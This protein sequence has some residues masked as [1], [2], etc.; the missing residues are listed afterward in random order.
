MLWKVVWGLMLGFS[1]QIVVEAAIIKDIRFN[2]MNN[3]VQLVLDLDQAVAFQQFSLANPPRI[4]L[5]F[6]NTYRIAKTGITINQGAVGSI[7]TGYRQKDLLRVVIDL[8]SVAKANIYTLSPDSIKGHRVVIDVYD[9]NRDP[10]IT[11]TSVDEG[12]PYVIFAGKAL[13]DQSSYRSAQFDTVISREQIPTITSTIVNNSAYTTNTQ[14]ITTPITNS[15]VIIEKKIVNNGL[16][17]KKTTIK[18]P[19]LAIKRDIVVCLDPGHGGK[20]PGAI[21]KAIKVREKDIVLSVARKLRKQLNKRSG[22]RVVMTRNSD[23]FIPLQ[24]RTR[25]CRQAGGDLFVSIHADAVENREPS[26]ASVY[27]LSTHGAT[28]QLAKYLANT[29]NAVDLKWG[30]DVS[31]YDNDIQEALLNI[32]QEATLESSNILAQKTLQQLGQIGNIHKLKVERANFVVLR[33]PEIPSMLVETG[34]IS[35]P[36]EARLLSTPVYQEKL[37]RGIASGIDAYFRE[38]LPQHMLL[39]Q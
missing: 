36:S 8:L 33:S 6:P 24:K 28:S 29:E 23:Q 21:S 14:S 15:K 34:F 30:V 19:P 35:N 7:R 5:D 22:Y 38:H 27:I 11:L 12:M 25:I 26:G 2:R 4:V 20:D 1:L 16:I 37:A 13:D 32:Q 9:I 39:E 31:K 10:A 18:S 17:Q 3:K